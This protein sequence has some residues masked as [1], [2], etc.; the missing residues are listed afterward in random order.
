MN[1]NTVAL[2][3]QELIKVHNELIAIAQTVSRLRNDP[4]SLEAQHETVV[5]IHKR[6]VL[7]AQR[8]GKLVG[9]HTTVFDRMEAA[10]A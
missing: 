10:H 3:K 5:R 7:A 9:K 1:T 6:S 2:E 4:M 8:I